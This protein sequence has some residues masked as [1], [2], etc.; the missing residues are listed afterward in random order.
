MH[1]VH[2]EVFFFFFDYIPNSYFHVNLLSTYRGVLGH[3]S[4]P[5]NRPW[6]KCTDDVHPLLAELVGRSC[7]IIYIFQRPCLRLS[8]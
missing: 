4:H 8:L 7:M 6:T 2:G 1:G 5:R 3:F